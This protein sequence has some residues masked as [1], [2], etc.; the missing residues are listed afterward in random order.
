MIIIFKKNEENILTKV[1]D[2]LLDL[3]TFET[4]FQN[5]FSKIFPLYNEDEYVVYEVDDSIGRS[6]TTMYFED[7]KCVEL[8]KELKRKFKLIPPDDADIWDN[9]DGEW[10]VNPSKLTLATDIILEALYKLR[11]SKHSHFPFAVGDKI[12]NQRW[13]DADKIY[14]QAAITGLTVS[15][16]PTTNW[17]FNGIDPDSIEA[18]S[19]TDMYRMFSAGKSNELKYTCA[20]LLAAAK[21]KAFISTENTTFGIDYSSEFDSQIDFL[22]SIP[23]L[24]IEVF[25]NSL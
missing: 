5:D 3:K 21:I 23:D 4:L 17:R 24:D 19:V 13:T 22:N 12:Y 9:I 1:A 2:T 6:I 18:L 16:F 8:T 25:Y 20:Q 11:T 15:K 7:E 10:V 14:I